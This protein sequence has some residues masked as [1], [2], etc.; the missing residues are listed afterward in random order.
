MTFSSTPKHGKSILTAR[1]TKCFIGY[2]E[3]EFLGHIVGQGTLKPKPDKVKAIQQAE[4]PTTKTHIKS[5]LGLAGY[6]RKFVPN[7][8]TVAVP[9]TYH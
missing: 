4:R 7:F 9:L 6:Y 2:N 1:P 3:V 8:A 5:F